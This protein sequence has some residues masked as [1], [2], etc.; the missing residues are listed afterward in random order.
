[1]LHII[2]NGND[3]LFAP[4]YLISFMH[5]WFLEIKVLVFISNEKLAIP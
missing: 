5:N 4:N 2:C 3:L 1:M